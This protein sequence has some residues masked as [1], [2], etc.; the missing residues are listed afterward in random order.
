MASGNRYS[1]KHQK[2]FISNCK[3]MCYTSKWTTLCVENVH[4]LFLNNSGKNQPILNNFWC[5]GFWR[6][7]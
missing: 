6:N 5:T 3:I 1:E 4:I 2:G 7:L